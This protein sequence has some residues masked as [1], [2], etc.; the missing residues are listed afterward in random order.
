MNIH[1]PF[2]FALLAIPLSL[3]LAAVADDL[4][5]HPAK[6]AKSHKE[7]R[8]EAEFRVKD[9][10]MSFNGQPLP[11]EV[12]DQLTSQEMLISLAIDATETFVASK[13]GAPTDLLRSYDK[14]EIKA[15]VGDAPETPEAENELEGKSI[16]FQWDDKTSEFK[17]SFHESKGDD[18]LL[19][20]LIDDMEVR[21][22]LP[23]KKVAKGDTWEV[24]AKDMLALF[25]PG[26]VAM[27]GAEKSADGPDFDEL[28]EEF[29]KQLE[30]SFQEFKVTCVYKG[31]R[32]DGGVQVGEIAFSY[33]GKASLDLDPLLRK[34]Q[35]SI[36]SEAPEMDFEATATMSLKGEGILLWD[37]ATGQ[38][39]SYEM[40]ADLGLDL[41]ASIHGDQGGETFEASMSGSI[42]GEVTW[43]MTTK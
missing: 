11:N 32:D 27:G 38:L 15:E 26:G 34:V 33:D 30:E 10:A 2:A 9:A 42:G 17:K 5:F 29:G 19:E 12:R 20:K 14:I 37:L 43:D 13:D 7:L 35:E 41:E 28:S 6:D 4:A 40:K 36:G 31:A 22:L 23:T 18:A 8:I 39:H 21:A 24:P 16:R 1:R 25:C 3:G